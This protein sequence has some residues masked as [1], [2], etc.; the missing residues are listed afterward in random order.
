MMAG[1]LM[2]YHRLDHFTFSLDKSV[3]R[4]GYCNSLTRKISLSRTLIEMNKE[5]EVLNTILHEIAHALSPTREHHGIFWQK[6]AKAI[7]CNGIRCYDS[8][9]VAR[10]PKKYQGQCPSCK[11]V[12]YRHRRKGISCGQCNPKFDSSL[13]FVWTER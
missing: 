2:T 13:L 6:T 12:I 5:D 8:K 10:P 4:F 11:R 3:S 1:D 9:V 7:G